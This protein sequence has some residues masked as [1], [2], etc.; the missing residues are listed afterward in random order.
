MS[1][2]SRLSDYESQEPQERPLSKPAFRHVAR[3][4]LGTFI[5]TFVASRAMVVLIMDQKVPDF[6]FH[7]GKTH[8]HH[9]N[10]GIFILSATGAVHAV[11]PPGRGTAVDLVGDLL[12]HRARADLR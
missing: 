1:D 6:F 7:V 9:L 3:I 10:Y 8:V 12:W 5:L 4:V 2:T 11:P